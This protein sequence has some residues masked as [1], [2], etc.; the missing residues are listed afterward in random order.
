MNHYD[1]PAF[2]RKYRNPNS[3]V[4]RSAAASQSPTSAAQPARPTRAQSAAPMRPRQVE[5]TSQ[6]A[7]S[8]GTH[9]SFRPSHVPEQLKSAL[10][11]GGIIRSTDDRNYLEIEASLHKQLDSF[12]LFTD[13]TA[14]DPT[15]VDLQQPLPASQ[16]APQSDAGPTVVFKPTQ[17]QSAVAPVEVF[18]PVQPVAPVV[19]AA[20]PNAPTEVFEPTNLAPVSATSSAESATPLAASAARSADSA[21]SATAESATAESATAESATA[22]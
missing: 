16:A 15:V 6:A 21:E 12:L 18:E 13:A 2:F 1:G 9:G 10:N 14:D 17:P 5:A 8:G 4:N 11:D 19:R 7:F 3:Q 20:M 22:E